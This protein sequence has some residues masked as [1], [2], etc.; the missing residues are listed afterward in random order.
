MAVARM[1]GFKTTGA[2]LRSVIEAQTNKLVGQ[3]IIGENNGM[4]QRFDKSVA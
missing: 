2:Q 4:F 1:L 3:E